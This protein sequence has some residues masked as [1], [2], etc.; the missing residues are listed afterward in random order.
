MFFVCL[1]FGWA[2]VHKFMEKKMVVGVLYLFT[3]G[4]FGF[5]W[6]IDCVK[7]ATKKQFG[8]ARKEETIVKARR[9]EEHEELPT[10]KTNVILSG[11]EVCHYSDTVIHRVMKNR[12]IGHAAGSSG[13]SFRIA[14]GVTIRTGGAKGHSVRGDVAEDTTGTL[15]VTNQRIVFSSNKDSFNKKLNIITSVVPYLDGV[16]IQFDSK[17]YLFITD[18]GQYIND[19]LKKLLAQ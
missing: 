5:G 1:F 7:Y 18:D 10:T 12:V 13:A 6:F 8:F 2:G 17:T 15:T 16:E 11:N 4:L 9:L 3:F 19:I 14:K